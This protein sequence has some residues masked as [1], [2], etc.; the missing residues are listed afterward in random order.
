MSQQQ[1][2][3]AQHSIYDPNRHMKQPTRK[4]ISSKVTDHLANERTFLA[5]VRTALAVMVFGFAVERVGLV[6]HEV[7]LK[8]SVLTSSTHYSTLVGV[9]LIFLGVVVLVFAL[10]NFLTVRSAIDNKNFHPQASFS[11]VLT[12]LASIIGLLLAVYLVVSG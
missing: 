9:A 8:S 10:I 6:L 2:E 7:G 12:V 1:K 5:W 11:I 4:F 3:Q